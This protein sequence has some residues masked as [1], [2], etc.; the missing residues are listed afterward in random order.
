MSSSW[1]RTSSITK[2]A[3]PSRDSKSWM[4]PSRRVETT[5]ELSRSVTTE[6]SDRR[7]STMSPASDSW[8]RLMSGA[9]TATPVL[10]VLGS[11]RSSEK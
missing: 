4:A 8:N 6:R 1:A 5:V 3:R 2:R 7:R 11:S 9:K 10:C